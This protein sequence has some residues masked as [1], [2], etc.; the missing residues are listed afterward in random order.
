MT[1]FPRLCGAPKFI[2]R[3]TVM[4][5][6]SV[7]ILA[8]VFAILMPLAAAADEGDFPIKADDGT[9]VANHR[10]APELV[11]QI[12]NLPGVIVVG[13]PHGKVTLAE[14]YDL[15]CP[16][17]RKASPD[18]AALVRD[19]AELRL[20]LVPFP[21]LGIASIQGSRVEL[22]V[23][24]LVSAQKF[25]DYHHKLYAGRGMIDGNRALEAAKAIGLDVAKVT[26]IANEDS[27]GAEMVAHVRLGN[28]LAI[29]ATPGFVINGV[30]ILGYPGAKAL[31]NVIQS[32]Q[33]CGNVVCTGAA[34]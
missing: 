28:A 32:V 31:A 11:G 15:N 12:E 10:V 2:A 13:N 19:N 25:F 3:T 14:F 21:V 1:L 23:A 30:A 26:K 27:I 17:C 16:Y 20:V 9:V 22:A 8:S 29:Q 7:L 5:R 6:L 24:R 18:I 33:R 4:S 34:H